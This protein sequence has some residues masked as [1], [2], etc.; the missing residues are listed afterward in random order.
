MATV[1]LHIGAPKTATSTLQHVLAGNYRK[2]LKHG[3]LYPQDLRHG[4][5]HHLLVCDLIE[6]YQDRP[7]PDIWY[8]DKPR[9][10]A[11]SSLKSEIERAGPD[12]HSVVLSTELFFGQNAHI[13]SML[14]D[15]SA[16]L[17]GHELKIV[18]YLR[19]QDQ[20]YSSFYNQD[21]KGVRQWAFS[22]YQF[23][24]THQIFQHD[25]LS[26]IN[27]WSEAFGRDNVIIRPFESQQW[28]NGDIVQ[29]FCAATGTVLLPSGYK[30]HNES[31]GI[32]QLYIKKCLNTIGFDKSENEAVIKVL[33]K[34]CPEEPVKGCCYVHR[35]LYRK[36][37]DQWV[38]TN[39]A[40]AV[41]YLGREEF[42]L[43]D[44]PEPEAIDLYT[45]DR[46]KV[47]GYAQHMFKI[48]KKG[49]R[50]CQYRDLFARATLL[51]LAEQNLWHCLTPREQQQMMKWI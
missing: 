50:Y 15:V 43:A 49:R 31:L 5:A 30:D 12:L 27:I 26:M 8:G 1:Y 47:A 32:T 35:G 40:I 24:Q 29:D 16:Q 28:V 17:E 25:Y 18:V 21:V 4:D 38:A 34:V 6:K 42:F 2:L 39:R 20:L 11:W 37:R 33:L 44:I 19:R 22:A 9:G 48:F 10:E 36:Y 7:M 3:V 14:R 41:D 23:Y 45:I 13:E 46:Y 51:A